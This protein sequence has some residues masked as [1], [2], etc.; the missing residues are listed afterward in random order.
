MKRISMTRLSL[1]ISISLSIAVASAASAVAAD[2]AAPAAKPEAPAVAAAEPA[3]PSGP[4]APAPELVAFAKGLEG[5]WKCDTKFMAGSMGPGSPEV[6]TKATVKL[7]KELDGFWYAG[8]YEVKKSKAMPGMKAMFFMGYDAGTKHVI[9]T[10]IDSSGGASL[11]TGPIEGDSV[12]ATGDGYLMGSKVKVRETMAK[13]GPKEMVHTFEVDMGH[14]FQML[15]EDT[16][17]K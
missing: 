3:A 17:K 9:L 1:S 14:G 12:T 7:K 5:S 4:P 11:E 6:A 10:G 15:G 2:K 13:K 16:C 8:T